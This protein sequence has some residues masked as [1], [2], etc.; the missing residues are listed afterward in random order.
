MTIAG[1]PHQMFGR[2][3]HVGSQLLL[4]QG[5]RGDEPG[6]RGGGRD[7]LAGELAIGLHRGQ[8][9][10]GGL[11]PVAQLAP[12][13]ELP[14]HQADDAGE[15]R[16]GVRDLEA[17]GADDAHL[18]PARRLGDAQ[19]LGGL[20]DLGGGHAQVGV[21]LHRFGDQRV[22]LRIAERRE[23]FV[24]HLT[25]HR[26]GRPPGRGDVGVAERLRAHLFG[27][28]RRLQRAAAAEQRSDARSDRDGPGRS[29]T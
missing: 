6:L 28:R 4:A 16:A 12:Q 20:L 9:G 19:L 8:A 27:R 5:L 26:R 18:R 21:A 11:L 2:A 13:V 1:Q 23:P 17:T 3:H 24:L 22:E 29:T 7:R 25:G 14:R 15:R 10:R